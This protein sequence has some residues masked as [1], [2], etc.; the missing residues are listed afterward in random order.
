MNL[1]QP[2]ELVTPTLDGGVLAVLARADARFTPGQVQK[3]MGRGALVGIR[4]VLDRMAAQG[5]VQ[6]ERTPNA[7]L[8]SLNWEHVGAK[9]VIGLAT[10]RDQ[11]LDRLSGA[12]EEF[13]IRP[14]YAALFGS[15]ARGEMR[16]ES[17]LDLFIVRPRRVDSENQRW[18]RSLV[19][20]SLAATR[21]TGN[22]LRVLEYGEAELSRRARSSEP[23][24]AAVLEE[25]IP[26][27][28]DP[29]WLRER[30]KRRST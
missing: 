4:K 26:L 5:I 20:L 12:L 27:V 21:W 7:V 6:A 25:G 15:A 18:Q 24:L 22:D 8:Y 2:F 1:T 29:A 17:D 16:S 19:D 11:I 30:V 3:L 13:P 23:V 28:G 9:W 14:T 10:L